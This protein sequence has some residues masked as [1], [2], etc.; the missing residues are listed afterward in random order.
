MTSW[1]LFV[2]VNQ[3]THWNLTFMKA[4]T[5]AP[6]FSSSFTIFACPP[7]QATNSAVPPSTDAQSTTAPFLRRI[8]VMSMKPPCAAKKSAVVP[9]WGRWEN[10]VR[11]TTLCA[12]VRVTHHSLRIDVSALLEQLQDACCVSTGGCQNQRSRVVL[13][14]K[15]KSIGLLSDSK[16]SLHRVNINSTRTN[17]F[18]FEGHELFSPLHA[19]ELCFNKLSASR[20]A[21]ANKPWI[22]IDLCLPRVF[23]NDLPIT[24]SLQSTCTLPLSRTFLSNISSPRSAAKCS[25]MSDK[26]SFCGVEAIWN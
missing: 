8:L 20:N 9:V 2:Y 21:F 14:M 4:L 18:A 6:A 7:W 5:L 11:N 26:V 12:G 23:I 16:I 24:S 13:E 1:R 10:L 22:T 19:C 17:K 25:W 3:A 15:I